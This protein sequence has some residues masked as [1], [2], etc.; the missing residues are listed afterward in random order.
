MRLIAI[1][2]PTTYTLNLDDAAAK[3]IA[4]KLSQDDRVAMKE[5]LVVAGIPESEIDIADTGKL[6]GQWES[7]YDPKK[8]IKGMTFAK[9]RYF[10]RVNTSIAGLLSTEGVI[11]AAKKPDTGALEQMGVVKQSDYVNISQVANVR[12]LLLGTDNFGRDVTTEL[13]RATGVSLL[14][15]LVAGLIA[16]SIGL[17]LGLLARVCR[18][19]GG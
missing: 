13:I 19:R 3:R 18:R 2:P 12:V 4:N 8:Q 5:W 10:Q 9:Q 1:N 11:V 6:L 15:G 7:N 16:T 14:I 17:T